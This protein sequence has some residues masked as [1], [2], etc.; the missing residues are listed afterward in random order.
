MPRSQSM[1]QAIALAS[2]IIP[3]ITRNLRREQARPR[4]L[5]IGVLSRTGPVNAAAL[6]FHSRDPP[7]TLGGPRD[8]ARMKRTSRTNARALL[9]DPATNRA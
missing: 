8:Q 6:R 1:F 9:S 5:A 4:N 2:S 3:K 7:T